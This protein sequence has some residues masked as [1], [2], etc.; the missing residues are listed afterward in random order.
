MCRIREFCVAL[1]QI[2]LV[3]VSESL[4]RYHFMG[5]RGSPS[6]CHGGKKSQLDKFHLTSSALV[7]FQKDSMALFI[8]SGVL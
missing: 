8:R 2:L 5:S 6:Q 7:I 3:C 1:A 4:N